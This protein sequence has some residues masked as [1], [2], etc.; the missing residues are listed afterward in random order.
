MMTIAKRLTI[1]LIVILV[2]TISLSLHLRAVRLLPEDYDEDVYLAA[3]QRYAAAIRQGDL[4][5]I[6]DY[7]FNFEHP[8]LTKLVYA[9]IILPLPETSLLLE[10]P[11]AEN[12]QLP[13][14]QPHFTLARLSSALF[15]TLEVLFLAILNPLAGLI[16]AI[17]TWQTKYTSQVMLEPLPA[18][19]SLLLVLCYIWSKGKTG[20]QRI[21]LIVLSAFWLGISAASKYTYAIAGIAVLVDWI[22]ES[23]TTPDYKKQITWRGRLRFLGAEIGEMVAWGMLAVIVFVAFNPRLWYDPLGRLVVSLIYHQDFTQ[24]VYVQSTGYPPWQ[25]FIWLMQPV[26]WDPGVFP[27]MIDPILTILAALGIPRLWKRQRVMALWLVLAAMILL[28]WPTKWPQ[29]LLNLLA[30][31]SLSAA[32]ALLGM[33]SK[34]IE[35]LSDLINGIKRQLTSTPS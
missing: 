14:P 1:T 3:A 15:G 11:S 23:L 27:I 31:Y 30:P 10:R 24:T 33:L 25:Q 12:P 21:S 7:K 34:P 26:P 19:T 9:L 5:A 8:A 20:V 18:L 2:A 32:E 29:Y 28:W 4:Q 6:I 13:L 16:L 17:S 22:L 35:F